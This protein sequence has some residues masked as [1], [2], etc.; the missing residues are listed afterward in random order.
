[1]TGIDPCERVMEFTIAPGSNYIDL[2]QCLS[3]VNRK[4]YR[5]GMEY[6]IANI[7]LI[8]SN[9]DIIT[10]SIQRVVHGWASANSWV[11]GFEHWN[12]Q[13]V[14]NL[15]EAG[16]LSIRGRYA[17]FKIAADAVHVTTDNLLPL[18]W[19]TPAQALVLDAD[20][21]Y[22]WEYSQ[23][24]IPVDGAA[25][26]EPLLHYVG[27][28]TATSRSLNY[29]YALSRA[30]PQAIDPNAV[31]NPISAIGAETGGLYQEMIDLGDISEEVLDHAMIHNQEPPYLV[32]N[33]SG[34][35][36]YPG[37]QSLTLAGLATQDNLIVRAGST[38][39]T[40][41]SGP[42]TAYCGL[43]HLLASVG[44][45]NALVRITMMPGDYAGVMA[46]PM[47]DVN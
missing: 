22:D 40:D 5:Q 42:F 46:R 2:A 18:N 16:A 1:M 43:L 4:M 24:L 15:R 28:D 44:A 19:L 6:V 14:D 13:V 3:Y 32:S 10:L 36:W 35:E 45:E 31:I 33:Y 27:A 37:G 26:E 38:V 25:P 12:Q 41:N 8:G 7:E 23:V 47:Q 11:K 34:Y 9:A 29:N 39:G 17:D 21:Q 30:R 20:V